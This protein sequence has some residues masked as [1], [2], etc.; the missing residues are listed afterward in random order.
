MRCRSIACVA[1]V[2]LMS[3][4][5]M[6]VAQAVIQADRAV[7]QP[8]IYRDG[9]TINGCGQRVVLMSVV[10]ER[11][12]YI[13]DF[14]ISVR[15]DQ[16]ERNIWAM[17][18]A[19]ISRQD[20]RKNIEKRTTVPIKSFFFSSPDG[21]AAVAPIKFIPAETAGF[22]LGIGRD[23]TGP[24][25]E[26]MLKMRAGERSQFGIHLKTESVARVYSYTPE[27]D[28]ADAQDFDACM[29]G[30]MTL[31]TRLQQELEQASDAQ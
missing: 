21:A 4:P 29:K 23:D 1:T 13:A 7:I 22:L 9:P 8:Q 11:E 14:S 15:A 24:A 28:P 18:K 5:H 6:A 27:I 30:F 26:L 3:A 31:I 2:I 17:T 25:A 16:K 12:A 10:S 20:P 19:G